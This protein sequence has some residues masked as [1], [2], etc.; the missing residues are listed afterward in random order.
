VL[1]AALGR[2]ARAARAAESPVDGP[3]KPPAYDLRR[4]KAN[5]ERAN[6][7]L[8][9]RS[10]QAVTKSPVNGRMLHKARTGTKA[11]V[12]RSA[13]NL[14]DRSWIEVGADDLAPF[15]DERTWAEHAFAADVLDVLTSRGL[16]TERLRI[17]DGLAVTGPFAYGHPARDRADHRV[18]VL[19]DGRPITSLTEL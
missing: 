15:V 2:I 18:G 5:G 10:L 14:L 3:H 12:F 11:A 8:A 13:I 16:V 4:A 7:A 1:V 9:H 19:V 17:V 6:H